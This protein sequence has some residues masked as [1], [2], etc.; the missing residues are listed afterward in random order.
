[1]SK[2]QTIMIKFRA[3]VNLRKNFVDL[4]HRKTIMNILFKDAWFQIIETII[5]S[6]NNKL[7][8]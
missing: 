7:D 4:L 1:M 3:Y 8:N 5:N 6:D 2:C